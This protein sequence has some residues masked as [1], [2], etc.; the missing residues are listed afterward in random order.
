MDLKPGRIEQDRGI[1][2]VDLRA[3]RNVLLDM[4]CDPGLHS[5]D[6]PR[7]GGSVI[8]RAVACRPIVLDE[9]T[10]FM[11]HRYELQNRLSC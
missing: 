7:E 3:Q 1:S 2:T 8:G 11:R 10:Q 4:G 9:P 5:R 6:Q